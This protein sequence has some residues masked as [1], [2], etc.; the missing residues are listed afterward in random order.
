M[1]SLS[2]VL[3][4]TLLPFTITALDNIERIEPP[5]WWVG[6]KNPKLQLMVY[7]EN[8]SDATPR[9]DYKGINILNVT[10][11]DSPNYLFIDLWIDPETRAG[12]FDIQFTRGDV[13]FSHRY[14]LWQREEGS[15]AREGFSSK[16]AL[17]LIMPDRFANGDPGND[18]VE[19]YGEGVNRHSR[20]ARHGGDLQGIVDHLDYL[21][22]LGVTAI[23]TNPVM[24]N[25]RHPPDFKYQYVYPDLDI[26]ISFSPYHGYAISDY[27]LIDPRLGTNE[28][29]RNM[30]AE[31][32]KRGIKVVMDMITNHCGSGHWWMDDLPFKDWIHD[33]EEFTSL[34]HNKKCMNDPY[35]SEI[36]RYLILNGWF[37]MNMPDMNQLNPFVLTY[38][39]QNTI[40]W[41]EYS[42]MTG[43]R[44]DTYLYNDYDAMATW[45][46]SVM[47]EYPGFSIVGENWQRES[48]EIAFW[49]RNSINPTG[50]QSHLKC[51]MDFPLYYVIP[52][53]FTEKDVV[54]KDGTETGVMRIYNILAN[55]YLFPNPSNILIFAENHDTPRMNSVLEGDMRGFKMTMAF[56]A[57]TR[58]IPQLYAG[59]EVMLGSEG[60]SPRV[61]FPGGWP[62]DAHNYFTREERGTYR[63]ESYDYL[64]NLLNWREHKEV[65][66]S[67]KLVH[68]IP[69]G[70]VYV[71][72]RF[73]EEESVLVILNNNEK[74]VNLNTKRFRERLEGFNSGFE[75]T[76]KRAINDL[77]R[78]E[79]PPKSASIIELKE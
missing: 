60:E 71:Y 10:K 63:N 14:E 68:F 35:G 41:I 64:K 30:V 66:H 62:G 57:T 39:I 3:W 1:K 33:H 77:S 48:H 31:C 4:L 42:G 61:D 74:P 27:Y 36:D 29:Y 28:A 7:G 79:L 75:I 9:I 22:D 45:A 40:W 15:S 58:G 70:G 44:M 18:T 13:N 76:G 51:V 19:G 16:D 59:C 24:E 37:S 53:C 20:N 52:E 50:Y 55:D 26:Q 6:M 78:I 17:Y 34:H 43:I 72:F 49:Q 8:I 73:N 67:G 56:L 46:K 32:S 54:I 11:A 38:F 5:N 69:H 25:R 65:I 12:S 2:L 23:W 21:K 47:D